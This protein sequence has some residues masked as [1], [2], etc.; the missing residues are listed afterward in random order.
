[1]SHNF[2]NL[3][4]EDLEGMVTEIKQKSTIL[5]TQIEHYKPELT[6]DELL[7]KNGCFNGI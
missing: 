5:N 4:N 7:N 2:N 1:M 3:T 6:L